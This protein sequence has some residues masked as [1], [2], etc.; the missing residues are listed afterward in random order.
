MFAPWPTADHSPTRS[1][2]GTQSRVQTASGDTQ[3]AVHRS[4]LGQSIRIPGLT[5]EYKRKCLGNHHLCLR[6]LLSLSLER[7]TSGDCSFLVLL[8][9]RCC[10]HV[11]VLGS[12][13]AI[14]DIVELTRQP[15]DK[16][17]RDRVLVRS[18]SIFTW[19]L[20]LESN[21]IAGAVRWGRNRPSRLGFT[22]PDPSEAVPKKFPGAFSATPVEGP[23]FWKT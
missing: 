4:S 13:V 6:M 17:P 21:A 12:W 23:L 15:G 14:I 8:W 10:W 1:M 18:P 3:N 16:A 2:A 5:T 9:P 11:R 22:S 7:G 20:W 19:T